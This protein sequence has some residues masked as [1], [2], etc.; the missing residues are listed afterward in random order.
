VAK[1]QGATTIGIT[2]FSQSPISQK[3]DHVLYTAS[4]QIDSRSDDTF[5]K[6]IQLSLID[7]LYVNVMSAQKGFLKN[8]IDKLKGY[9]GKQ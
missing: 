1:E 4:N 5:S 9:W 6:I 2:N 7:A 8:S 3:A